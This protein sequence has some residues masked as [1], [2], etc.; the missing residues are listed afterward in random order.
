MELFVGVL[1][2]PFFLTSCGAS[3]RGCCFEATQNLMD[4]LVVNKTY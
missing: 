1:E 3:G 4:A 2:M